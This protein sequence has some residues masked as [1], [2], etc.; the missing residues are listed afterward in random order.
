MN[1]SSLAPVPDQ[2]EIV[3][4]PI[5]CPSEHIAPHE[6]FDWIHHAPFSTLIIDLGQVKTIHSNLLMVL[7]KA[8]HQA[9]KI[10]KTIALT[11]VSPEWKI[12]LEISKLDGLFPILPSL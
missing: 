8:Q 12:V 6:M 1:T 9:R 4:Q 11:S 10:S 5:Y 3:N 2:L 7:A